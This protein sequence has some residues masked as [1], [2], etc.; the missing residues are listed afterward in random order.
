MS[1]ILGLKTVH[2]ATARATKL[3]A[4]NTFTKCFSSCSQRYTSQNKPEAP[5]SGTTAEKK[6]EEETFNPHIN[7]VSFGAYYGLQYLWEYLH[8]ADADETSDATLVS[9]DIVVASEPK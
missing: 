4:K 2:L 3:Q 6:S 7:L 5:L 9:S 1:S 8:D